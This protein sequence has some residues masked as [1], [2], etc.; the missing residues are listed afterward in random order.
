MTSNATS[1]SMSILLIGS[2]MLGSPDM[3]ISMFMA[4]DL[5]SFLPVIDLD[6]TQHQGSLL[7]GSNHLNEK[8][9]FIRDLAC[10][11]ARRTS[12]FG[13]KCSNLLRNALKE[14]GVLLT[15]VLV[16]LMF[17]IMQRC[18][19]KV[20]NSIRKKVR[21]M[22]FKVVMLLFDSASSL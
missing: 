13:F 8:P 17:F 5:I 16:E 20:G 18:C 9:T 7:A 3:F 21:S 4:I 19:D 22:L 14:L 1:G 15:L 2:A 12:D 10:F 11:P 6:F